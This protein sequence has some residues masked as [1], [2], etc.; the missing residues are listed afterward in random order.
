MATK[1][2]DETLSGPRVVKHGSDDHASLLGLKKAEKDDA[3]QV[4]GWTLVDVTAF[5]PQATEAYIKEV[6]RQKVSE[7]KAGPPPM[8]QSK[9]PYKPNY[10][11]PIWVPA[12]D[13]PPGFEPEGV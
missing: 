12:D 3:Y 7:L 6:L 2:K 9:D 4:D 5:G 8:P 11:P 13:L 1:A 10:A